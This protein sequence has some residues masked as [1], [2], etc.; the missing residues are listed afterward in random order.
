MSNGSNARN[1]DI[2]VNKGY[3]VIR[4]IKQ[5]IEGTSSAQHRLASDQLAQ[6]SCNWLSKALFLLSI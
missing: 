1:I 2:R 3:G 6:P 4:D 5:I